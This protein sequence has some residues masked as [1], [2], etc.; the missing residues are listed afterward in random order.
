MRLP[1]LCRKSSKLL[2]VCKLRFTRDW[3]RSSIHVV[4][5]KGC[6][7]IHHGFQFR[8]VSHVSGKRLPFAIFGKCL[9]QVAYAVDN[10]ST[11]CCQLA[12]RALDDR[13]QTADCDMVEAEEMRLDRFGDCFAIF[14]DRRRRWI[15]MQSSDWLRTWRCR[16]TE[17][18]QCDGNRVTFVT[19]QLSASSAPRPRPVRR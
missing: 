8:G 11:G 14:P 15:A 9:E 16:T 19:R 3:I 4:G 2:E 7:G 18:F 13:N 12:F 10:N 6:K 5:G 17:G 1:M